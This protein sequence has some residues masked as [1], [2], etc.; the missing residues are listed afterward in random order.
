MKNNALLISATIFA[1]ILLSVITVSCSDS[2]TKF[3]EFL[4]AV[5]VEYSDCTGCL[6]CLD[7]FSCPEG[8]IKQDSRTHTV[9][10]DMSECINCLKC[11]NNFNCPAEAFVTTKDMI[12]PSEIIDLT[13]QSDSIGKLKLDF[14]AP[15]D[16]DGTG[17]SFRYEFSFKN[18]SGDNIDTG[19][20]PELPLYGGEK[21]HYEIFGLPEYQTISVTVQAFD[22]VKSSS[23]KATSNVRIEGAHI[24]SIPPSDITDLMLISYEYSVKLMWTA[25][26]NDGDEGSA[27]AYIIKR[28]SSNISESNFDLSATVTQ[29]IS[30]SPAGS[31]DSLE[32]T[33]LVLGSVYYFAVKSI[34]SSD[35][36]SNISNIVNGSIY[37]DIKPPSQI[38]D[39][40]G[41]DISSS[42]V[43]IGWT[44]PYDD[45]KKTAVTSYI[46][47]ISSENI[48]ET[49]WSSLPEYPN[50]I[51][52]RAGGTGESFNIT[53]LEPLTPY[54]IAIRSADERN[55]LSPLSNV[56]SVSTTA[57]P[58]TFPPAQVAD[59][60]ITP[61]ADRLILEW[62]APG[63]DGITGTASEYILKLSEN[64]ITE[65]SFD[66]AISVQNMPAP[67]S[68]GSTERIEI[69]NL[70]LGTV[71]YFALKTGDEVQNYS[72]ISNIV[73]GSILGD[74]I[75]PA[76]ISNL[77]IISG[78]TSS[79]TSIN[80]SW[81]ATG[82]DNSTGIASSYDIRYLTSPVTETNWA[83]AF[84]V[85]GEPLPSTPGST[86]NCTVT[87]LTKGRLY[88][89]GI[90]AKDEAGNISP[91]SNVKSG[92]IVYSVNT[93]CYGC[94][95]CI[96]ACSNSAITMNSG[97]AVISSSKCNACGSCVSRCPVSAI[98]L[99]VTAY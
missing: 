13:A 73:S 54:Y 15:G 49:N 87:G 50:S 28:S 44:A 33:D 17:R 57:V 60:K 94:G 27:S 95:R 41:S 29:S 18:A 53:E 82:D 38:T 89:F 48:S 9:Y 2:S 97:K 19:F 30:V 99:Y 3:D 72:G 93:S 90:K 56:L 76:R 35:N 1:L 81:T 14:T 78:Y 64:T 98:K 20:I 83:S 61:A 71:Y 45:G 52:P 70:N 66:S 40:S 26:G 23:A 58:D 22:E 65:S 21:E 96:S 77:K 91:L 84:S 86:Q 59:M 85:T 46:I 10:I 42:S 39:L 51:I 32:I 62:T 4:G 6:E 63:D 55:N 24:D 67:L 88:Y 68:P 25:P 75:P 37:G 34:D 43:R 69:A 74:I 36:S 8:A 92:K 47:K 31:L 7:N 16:D 12:R 79:S 80:L 11:I 5:R